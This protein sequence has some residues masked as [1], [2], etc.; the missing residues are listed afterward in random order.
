MVMSK[1]NDHKSLL[2]SAVVSRNAV[3]FDAAVACVEHDLSPQEVSIVT[4]LA[5][6]I[7]KTLWKHS[8]IIRIPCLFR[9]GFMVRVSYHYRLNARCIPHKPRGT[10]FLFP[11]TTGLSYSISTYLRFDLGPFSRDW[12]VPFM[13]L[14]GRCR[15]YL[16]VGISK[17][18]PCS[19]QR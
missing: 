11:T 14:L 2:H 6:S 18:I 15:L 16:P 8:H 7:S 9:T 19:S 3:M 13:A 10:I 17:V 4:R 5:K 1:S 12:G